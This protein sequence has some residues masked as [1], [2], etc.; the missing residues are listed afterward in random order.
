MSPAEEASATLVSAL[1]LFEEIGQEIGAEVG[2]KGTPQLSPAL[3][4]NWE[5][6]VESEHGQL[7][8][9]ACLPLQIRATS[10]GTRGGRL[11]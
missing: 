2:A 11:L 10:R 3:C 5:Q 4:P 7:V 8:G 9:G 1:A 6:N